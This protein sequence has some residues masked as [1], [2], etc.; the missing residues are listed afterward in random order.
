MMIEERIE[1]PVAP[2]VVFKIWRE[3]D[4]W[5]EWDPD[6]KQA[7]LDGPFAAG[8]TGWLE[9]S[10]GRGVKITISECTPD[11]SFTCVGG[12]PGFTM[13]FAH[14]V[15]AMP[16]GCEVTHRVSFSGWLRFIF[17]QLIG[18]QIRKGLPVTMASLKRYAMAR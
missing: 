3:V 5:K 1:I 4:R 7:R 18:A 17:G 15:R 6:T 2:S 8:S 11:H 13:H 12:I 16:A 14:E 10:K 9:P